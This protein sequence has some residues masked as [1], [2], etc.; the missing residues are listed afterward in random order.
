MGDSSE[1]ECPIGAR[2]VVKA[3][4]EQFI[5]EEDSEN[6]DSP[7]PEWISQHTPVKNAKQSTSNSSESDGIINLGSP[8][9]DEKLQAQGTELE[10]KLR[11][12][13]PA[14]QKPLKAKSQT[15]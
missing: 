2:A 7:L 5:L 10:G 11:P 9:T 13:K 12:T 15:G 6:S 8:V 3:A 4:A 14:E 1:D